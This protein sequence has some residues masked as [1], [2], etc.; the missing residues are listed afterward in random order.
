[1][2]DDKSLEISFAKNRDLFY[3][4]NFILE[5]IPITINKNIIKFLESSVHFFHIKSELFLTHSNIAI[6]SRRLTKM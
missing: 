4:P 2:K 3:Y 6:L 5:N 1:M